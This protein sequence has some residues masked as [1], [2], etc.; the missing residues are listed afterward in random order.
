MTFNRHCQAAS[1]VPSIVGNLD[2]PKC[3]TVALR[4]GAKSAGKDEFFR[5]I[6]YNI[7]GLVDCYCIFGEKMETNFGNPCCEMFIRIRI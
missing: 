6:M 2:F 7:Q 5:Y 3:F 4:K 1:L